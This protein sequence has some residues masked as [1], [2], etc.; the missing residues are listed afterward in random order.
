MALEEEIK[1]V[2]EEIS[3][4]KY[5]KA[6][7]GHIG[8]LKAKLSKLREEVQK[9]ASQKS[10]GEGFAV[11][12]SG[13]ASVVI[14]GFPSVGKSTL[15]NS[16][17]GT[18]S[19]VA[20]YEFTTL[21]VVPGALEYKG[22][23]I[24]ILDVPGILK[25]AA[26]GRGR[27]KEV[28]AVVRNADLALIMLDV[29]QLVHY[30]VLVEELY[31]AGIRINS[32]PPEI[33]IRKKPRGGVSISS[34][35]DVGLDEDT[36]KSI[37]GEYR[38]H[39]ASVVI[40]EDI[41]IDKLIDA[42]LGNRKYIPAVVVINKIDLADE[43]TLKECMEK[44]PDALLV[45]A[46]QKVHIEELKELIYQKLGFIRVFLKPQGK[47]A[48]M[49]EPLIVRYSSTIGDICDRLH[50]D[51]RKRFRYAQVWGDSAKHRGQHVGLEH[52]LYDNDILTIIL[53][54]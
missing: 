16:L 3:R 29:F 39:N 52:M 11:K 43:N 46:D 26:S 33:T 50:R 28:L 8:R 9:R 38:M 21:D 14:L 30:E 41:T 51:F 36:I 20:S 2:E 47:D 15:L 13:D 19:A 4:T 44:F 25:G 42:V 1:A 10:G 35:V 31:A 45:S 37:L 54:K 17:T 40:R 6:T 22:A 32:R 7:E 18:K 49:D 34:T 5:N 53:R 48:D 27:G 23:T 12:K 24:Q